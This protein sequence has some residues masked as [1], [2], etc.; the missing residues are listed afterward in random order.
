[1]RAQAVQ[2]LPL[3][4]KGILCVVPPAHVHGVEPALRG[5]RLRADARDLAPTASLRRVRCRL[6]R[7]TNEKL[8]ANG[9]RV[10]YHDPAQFNRAFREEMHCSPREYKKASSVH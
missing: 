1:M 6:I 8:Y 9:E 4:G 10:G 2:A 7:E 5:E 3:A